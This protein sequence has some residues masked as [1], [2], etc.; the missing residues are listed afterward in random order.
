MLVYLLRHGDAED[1]GLGGARSDEERA[2]TPVGV[3]R[4]QAACR[5]YARAMQTVDRIVASPLQRAQQTARILAEAL[6]HERTL[7]TENLLVPSAR[8]VQALDLLQAEQSSGLAGIAL[9]GHEPHLGNLLGLLV[10]GSDRASIPLKKGMLV[11][12]DL[13]RGHSMLGRLVLCLG[14]KSAPRLL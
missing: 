9:V 6:G 2:L 8:P 1:L 14:Q 4:L 7:A 13:E 12:V 5:V 3:E 10:T 11:G